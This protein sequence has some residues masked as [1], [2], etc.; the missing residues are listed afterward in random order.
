[1]AP[2]S[3]SL[4]AAIYSPEPL[5]HL[6]A[7]KHVGAVFCHERTTPG[8]TTGV[9][10]I[11][12][13]SYA[14]AGSKNT[15]AFHSVTIEGGCVT[16]W[17]PKFRSEFPFCVSLDVV[18]APTDHIQIDGGQADSMDASHFTLQYKINN[19]PGTVDGWVT[20]SEGDFKPLEPN[21]DLKFRNGPA[22]RRLTFWSTA[23][24]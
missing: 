13:S 16:S 11:T 6:S 5:K 2:K 14:S 9:V 7:Y 23:Y 19:Q 8:G 3:S 18:V 20:D 15:T 4:M 22:T 24:H 1:M 17:N 21:V 12:A 10:V